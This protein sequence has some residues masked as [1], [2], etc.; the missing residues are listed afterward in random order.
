MYAYGDI[1]PDNVVVDRRSG[2]LPKPNVC[3]RCCVRVRTKSSWTARRHTGRRWK[4]N[5]CRSCDQ[6]P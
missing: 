3:V 5:L 6:V 2:P 1:Q 4:L